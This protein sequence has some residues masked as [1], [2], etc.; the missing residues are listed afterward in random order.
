MNT[1]GRILILTGVILIAC[2]MAFGV[3]YALFD[4]HQ[5]LVGMGMHMATGF[6]EASNGNMEAAYSALDSYGAL[7]QEYRNEVH[8]HGH[9]GMLSLILIVLGLVFDRLGL[10]Q[11]KGVLLASLLAASTALF[12][13]GV[14]L[15]IG[16]AASLGKILSMAGSIGMILG[17]LATVYGLFRSNDT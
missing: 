8:S 16:P 4:E 2:T 5:T 3:G 10:E 1:A 15:Q 11:R 14:L 9:W 13:L 17:L 6:M 7:T 12:P